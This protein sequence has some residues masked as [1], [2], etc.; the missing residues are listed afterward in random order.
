M[1]GAVAP[2]FMNDAHPGTGL[3]H[4]A[5]HRSAAWGRGGG[6]GGDRTLGTD[7]ARTLRALGTPAR[8]VRQGQPGGS[9]ERPD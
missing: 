4:G 9:A 3:R 6:G 8:S 1:F 5:R 7:R 2:V